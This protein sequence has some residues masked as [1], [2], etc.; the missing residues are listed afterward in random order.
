MCCLWKPKKYSFILIGGNTISFSTHPTKYS[1]GLCCV[2]YFYLVCFRLTL[3][4]LM[5]P[6]LYTSQHFFLWIHPIMFAYYY[7]YFQFPP[8]YPNT[9]LTQSLYFCSKVFLATQSIHCTFYHQEN[10][11]TSICN[12]K[13][14]LFPFC[15]LLKKLSLPN[16]L[17]SVHREMNKCSDIL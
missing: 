12:M 10:C 11:K 15:L 16:L 5:Q 13:T 2:F 7:S 17:E 8:D 9:N 3:L 14:Y 1:C 6:F 4:M